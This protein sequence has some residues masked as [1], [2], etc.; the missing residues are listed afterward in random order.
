MPKN[1]AFAKSAFL[2]LFIAA[3]T[4]SCKK[5][6]GFEQQKF[7][8][9]L[10]ENCA[11]QCPEIVIELPIAQGDETPSDSINQKV[12]ATM[13]QI[14][15][16]GEKPFE[17]KNYE[18][19]TDAFMDSYRKMQQKDPDE[20]FGWEAKI[21][22]EVLYNSENLINI[23][24]DHYTFTG[25]AHGYAGKYS[26]IFDAKTGHSVTNE[27]LF[28]DVSAFARYAEGKFRAKFGIG[29]DEPLNSKGFMFEEERFILPESIMFDKKGLLLF[30]N[31]YEIASYAQ[32]PQ[33]LLLPYAEVDAYLNF[34]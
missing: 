9:K 18:E 7:H 13:K 1:S 3:C 4:V 8:K 2:L 26:L 6:I 20:R 21:S 31:P 22:G 24:L 27:M 34:K 25:G 11:M 5:S 16:V 33:E 19:L 32:G 15:Y 14:V 12:L 10:A 29:N 28:K 30:Y 17:S 23:V